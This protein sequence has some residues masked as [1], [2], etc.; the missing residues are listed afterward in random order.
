LSVL[1]NL[2][3]NDKILQPDHEAMAATHTI[4]QHLLGEC[5]LGSPPEPQPTRPCCAVTDV[6][7]PQ[8]Q[9]SSP[10]D[11][12]LFTKSGADGGDTLR[13]TLHAL[14]ICSG[15]QLDVRHSAPLSQHSAKPS[16]RFPGPPTAT[17][18]STTRESASSWRRS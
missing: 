18:N 16:N 8:I 4:G 2:G 10:N 14:H 9:A 5:G 1:L 11:A 3:Q 6:P 7:L 12:S 15:H 17:V 13:Q